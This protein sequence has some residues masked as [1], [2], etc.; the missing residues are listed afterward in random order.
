MK[1]FLLSALCALAPLAAGC[2]DET[3]VRPTATEATGIFSD[4]GA[5]RP[6]ATAEQHDTF[7]RGRKVAIRRFTKA[8]G[9]GPTY[10]VAS[11]GACHERPVIGGAGARY[12]QFELVAETLPDGSFQNLGKS[13]VLDHYTLDPATRVPTPD[14]TNVMASRVPIPFFGVGLLAEIPDAAI[15]ANADPDDADG[16]G[17]S[18][19][20]NYDRGFVGRFGRKSQTVSIEGFI[21]GPIFNH[22]GITSDPLP[23]ALRNQL[24]VP[25]GTRQTL[26]GV[27]TNQVLAVREPEK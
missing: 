8:D 19:R 24:P 4:L 1:R 11:C 5:I 27:R 21:R 25:S 22:A 7:E 14:K 15:L 6:D 2:N 18:G 12:R 10:N 23:D 20:P 9:L 17:V 13:G 3:G 26:R 16:D